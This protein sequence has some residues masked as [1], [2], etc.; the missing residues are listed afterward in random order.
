MFSIDSQSAILEDDEV[1]ALIKPTIVSS[2]SEE[3]VTE[4]IQFAILI[5]YVKTKLQKTSLSS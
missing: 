4:L 2:T 1:E 3:R 5:L